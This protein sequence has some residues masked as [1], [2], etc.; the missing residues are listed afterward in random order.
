MKYFLL[1]FIVSFLIPE[2]NPKEVVGNSTPS[3]D[4]IIQK[5]HKNVTIANETNKTSDSLVSDKVD[6][7]VKKISNL[8][9][10]VKQLKKEKDELEKEIDDFDNDGKPFNLRSIS[11]N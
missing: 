4:T 5:V 2:C 6:K 8:E 1:I 3:L 7:T 10:E 11:D 9:A